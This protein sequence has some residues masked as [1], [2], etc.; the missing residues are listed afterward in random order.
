MK[1]LIR[2][3]NHNNS[4]APYLND[5]FDK[6]NDEELVKK[7]GRPCFYAFF[8]EHSRIAYTHDR[9][10]HADRIFENPSQNGMLIPKRWLS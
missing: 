1:P 5:L 7:E 4:Y 10:S 8:I 2:I 9:A 6:T 3:G